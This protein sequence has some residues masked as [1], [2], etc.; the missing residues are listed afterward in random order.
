[1]KRRDVLTGGA[2][3]LAGGWAF[4]VFAQTPT[5][6]APA[7]PPPAPAAPP[8]LEPPATGVT[9]LSMTTGQGVLILDLFRD[10]APITTANILKY[11]DAHRYDGAKFFRALRNKFDPATGLI[12][13]D[14]KPAPA[15]GIPP[16]RHE[17]TL[18][19]GLTHKDGTL[20]LARFAV[21]T[22]TSSVFI[23]IG[24]QPYLDAQPDQP[25]DNQG[26]A[27]FGQVVQGMDIVRR[28][29]QM[30]TGDDPKIPWMKGEILKPPVPI[31]S[32]RRRA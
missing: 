31:V 15:P 29:H 2:G 4:D 14:A 24:D 10:K 1:M 17:S 28:I 19:T 16:I 27:A 21:G 11:V 8:P 7:A 5:T 12:Q 23:V 13:F 6:D 26:F 30:P 9:R 25:G 32:V 20:S 18:T 22:A 3:L